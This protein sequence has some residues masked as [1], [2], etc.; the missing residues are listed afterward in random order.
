MSAHHETNNAISSDGPLESGNSSMVGCNCREQRNPFSEPA[1]CAPREP[2]LTWST[3]YLRNQ[4]PLKHAAE[5]SVPTPIKVDIEAGCDRPRVWHGCY[6]HPGTPNSHWRCSLVKRY[7]SSLITA[8]DLDTYPLC[9]Q[10]WLSHHGSGAPY[11]VGAFVTPT[12]RAVWDDFVQT[13]LQ[14]LFVVE[15]YRE[16]HHHD[17]MYVYS[18]RDG[19]V[20]GRHRMGE[21]H[22]GPAWSDENLWFSKYSGPIGDGYFVHTLLEYGPQRLIYVGRVPVTDIEVWGHTVTDTVPWRGK[23]DLR[24]VPPFL[25]LKTVKIKQTGLIPAYDHDPVPRPALSWLGWIASGLCWLLGVGWDGSRLHIQWSLRFVLLIWLYPLLVWL[26][27]WLPRVVL[28]DTCPCYYL[29]GQYAQLWSEWI[30]PH[31]TLPYGGLDLPPG[32]YSVGPCHI[33]RVAPSHPECNYTNLLPQAT[34]FALAAGCSQA[35]AP[36]ILFEMFGPSHVIPNETSLL[37]QPPP[38]PRTAITV[39]YEARIQ[40]TEMKVQIA[41]LDTTHCDFTFAE[42]SPDSLAFS[43]EQRVLQPGGVSRALS[44]ERMLRWWHQHGRLK[45]LSVSADAPDFSHYDGRKRR[46]YERNYE[47]FMGAKAGYNCFL[48]TEV[49]PSANIVKGKATR[50]IQA[51]NKKFNVLTFNFFHAFE[52]ELLSIESKTIRYRYGMEIVATRVPM[53]A[54]GLNMAERL[55]VIRK[56][57]GAYR[58]TLSCD[59]KNFDGHNKGESYLAEIDFYQSIGLPP[60]I[61]KSLREAKSWGAFETAV[62][63]RH[64]GDLFTGSGNCLQAASILQWVGAEHTIFCDGDDTLVFTNDP[65]QTKSLLIGRA[66]AAGH[67][68]TFDDVLSHDLYGRMIPFCQQIFLERCEVGGVIPS[69]DRIAEKLWNIPCVSR[70]DLAKRLLGKLQAACA[71]GAAGVPGYPSLHIVYPEDSDAIMVQERM[72]DLVIDRSLIEAIRPYRPVS[73][74]AAEIIGEITRRCKCR[75]PVYKSEL[76]DRA[77][78]P[79]L[80]QRWVLSNDHERALA[81]AVGAPQFPSPASKATLR[82][83]KALK[84]IAREYADKIWDARLSE[85][86]VWNRG[87]SS[88]RLVCTATHS[89]VWTSHFG[90]PELLV[91]TRPMSCTKSNFMSFRLTALSR[92]DPTFSASTTTNTTCQKRTPCS[93]SSRWERNC[94]GS[95]TGQQCGSQPPSSGELPPDDTHLEPSPTP[96]MP[97]SGSQQPERRPP[98]PSSLNTPQRSTPRKQ[99]HQQ[100][101]QRG[102]PTPQQTPQMPQG[103]GCRLTRRERR[104]QARITKSG[105]KPPGA[106]ATP[107]NQAKE[108]RSPQARPCSPKGCAGSEQKIRC[109]EKPDGQGPERLVPLNTLSLLA[110]DSTRGPRQSGGGSNHSCGTC[111]TQSSPSSTPRMPQCSSSPECEGQRPPSTGCSISLESRQRPPEPSST[112]PAPPSSPPPIDPK[113]IF[114]RGSKFAE[115]STEE[116]LRFPEFDS[117]DIFF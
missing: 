28:M 79:Y 98:S 40:P 41:R 25:S 117:L 53:F 65:D 97:Q 13:G 45:Q 16:G 104:R 9:R 11:V 80:P 43:L 17:D 90:S 62:T 8:L 106:N 48:K 96:L 81:Q 115:M 116:L 56:L 109:L 1:V 14:G 51:N 71:Y 84:E 50:C 54:K 63:M 49:L 61:A 99:E 23:V 107:L 70:E 64:S 92:P 78:R 105:E 60:E 33:A 21:R 10:E 19:V 32:F 18:C 108:C 111:E 30:H 29:T 88:Q 52:K 74:L 6:L 58:Y 47:A 36:R 7:L 69:L 44:H 67:E 42:P 100:A 113:R 102:S 4:V 77:G 86:D 82:P 38:A 75:L 35:A 26:S 3:G 93:S 101:Q 59:F 72:E 5:H 95:R 66:A 37:E 76:P 85:S 57:C 91:S 27:K 73:G 83:D 103:T 55:T 68:L 20:Y 87:M 114:P 89:Q 31:A 46:L 2:N 15:D 22:G 112:E 94:T 34:Q 110:C 12:L 24:V 39:A